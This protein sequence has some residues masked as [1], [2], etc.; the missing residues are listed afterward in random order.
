LFFGLSTRKYQTGL[1]T[2][3]QL[4][5]LYVK[6]EEKENKIRA[7]LPHKNLLQNKQKAIQL[8]FYLPDKKLTPTNN[9]H[10]LLQKQAK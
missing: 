10:P 3:S 2:Q 5:K 7:S 8:M 9:K 6:V 1:L 4:Y